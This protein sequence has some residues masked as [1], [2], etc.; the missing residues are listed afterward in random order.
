M[1]K[2]R[3]YHYDAA[4]RLDYRTD[5]KSQTITYGYN[6][7]NE[8]TLIDY[9]SGTDTTYAYNDSGAQ[10]QMVDATG[11][12]TYTYDNLYRLTSVTFPGSRTVGYGYDDAGRRT[13]VTY[14]GGSNTVTYGYDNAN[15]NTSVTDWNSNATTYAYDDAG[16][17]TTT[18]LPSGT[19]IVSTYSYDNA[20]RLTGIS[21]V[22]S[23]PGTI[24]SV[25]Y[26]LD[27]VG[28]RT[29]RVDQAGTHTYSY[30]DIYRLTSVTYPGPATTTYAFDAFGNRTSMTQ[31]GS[32][33]TTYTYNDNDRLTSVTKPGPS[34]TNYTWDDNGDLTARG[35]D[36]FAWDYEDRMTQSVVSS[37]TTNYTYRGDGLRNTRAVSGGATTTF[38]WDINAGLPVIL[39]DGN[40][41]LYGAAGLDAQK[42]GGAWY[43]YLADGL[44]STMAIVNASGVVQDSYIYDIY[45]KPS[46]TGTLA[47]EFDFA[48]QQTD[49][50]GLQYLRARYMDPQTGT[51]L[52]REPMSSSIGWT[53]NPYG[54]ALGSPAD[55]YDPSGKVPVDSCDSFCGD[56]GTDGP[57]GVSSGRWWRFT[58]DGAW[59]ICTV[60]PLP[61]PT[62]I[63]CSDEFKLGDAA[64]ESAPSG[65][66][67]LLD[68][69]GQVVGTL[70][71]GHGARHM[72]PN[73][74]SPSDVESAIAEDVAKRL[75][76]STPKPGDGWRVKIT[77]NGT[78]IE[79]RAHVLKD[80]TV[81]IGT[82]F[83]PK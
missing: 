54:Y 19:G 76:T 10:T 17:M 25:A 53:G 58:S 52:S 47:N 73:D 57:V 34:T 7:R 77:V 23:G 8:L 50:T 12:T 65:L 43:Y 41:Y 80:G 44:G 75:K 42:Q 46:K 16:R 35:S 79:Y 28:N 27:N 32:Q 9:P 1:S 13:S 39:D 71:F 22:K 64:T 14:P 61:G 45:G 56:S 21:H 30:D 59:H 72:G 49:D 67:K 31:P 48:G 2:V 51:F 5:P 29:Q 40:Q 68:E 24:A 37:V 18:T 69:Y 36:S 78:T 33:T 83:V 60:V 62:E 82:Y 63:Y 26:T 81:N 4:S 20:D 70:S 55:V 38:T 6:D 11:T 74:P 3:T 15:R 66:I